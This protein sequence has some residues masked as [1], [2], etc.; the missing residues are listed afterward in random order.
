MGF[1]NSLDPERER[2]SEVEDLL[3]ENIHVKVLR[4]ERIENTKRR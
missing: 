2:K 4:E 3:L 1:N